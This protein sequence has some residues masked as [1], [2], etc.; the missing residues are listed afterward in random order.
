VATL[1]KLKEPA[2]TQT[3]TSVS[4]TVRFLLQ[5]NEKAYKAAYRNLREDAPERYAMVRAHSYF[6][7]AELIKDCRSLVDAEYLLRARVRRL[8]GSVTLLFSDDLVD[9][10]ELRCEVL[11]WIVALTSGGN[12]GPHAY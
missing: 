7:V 8:Q 2:P 12:R 1:R 5:A 9:E 6:E 4:A 10:I 3:L 11:M